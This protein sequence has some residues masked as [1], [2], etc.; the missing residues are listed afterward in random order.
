MAR[1]LRFPA[2]LPSLTTLEAN[3]AR[4]LYRLGE[5]LVKALILF[6][7]VLFDETC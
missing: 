3:M 5:N 1:I 4:E 7:I 6:R 2:S